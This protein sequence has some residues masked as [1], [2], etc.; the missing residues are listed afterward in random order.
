MSEQDFHINRIV[1]SLSQE[2]SQLE[3]LI[4]VTQEEIS[5]FKGEFYE[6]V[7][8]QNPDGTW[9]KQRIYIERDT[10]TAEQKIQKEYEDKQKLS[11]NY[12]EVAIPYDKKIFE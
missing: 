12:K 7:I 3:D 1:D 8:S 6:D 4:D 9:S 5:K 11:V 10:S 2:L